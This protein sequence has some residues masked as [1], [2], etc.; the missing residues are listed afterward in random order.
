M[1]I[2]FL[3]V[4]ANFWKYVKINTMDFWKIYLKSFNAVLFKLCIECDWMNVIILI[5]LLLSMLMD[6]P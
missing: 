1:L 5:E 2:M 3:A 4:V 6:L